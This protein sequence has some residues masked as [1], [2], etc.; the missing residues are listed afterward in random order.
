MGAPVPAWLT[1]LLDAGKKLAEQ[2]LD[3]PDDPDE[4]DDIFNQ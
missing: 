4:P 3:L 2:Q 1:K